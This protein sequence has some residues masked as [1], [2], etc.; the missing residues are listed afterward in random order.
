MQKVRFYFSGTQWWGGKKRK[1]SS[2]D[3]A[4]KESIPAI[5]KEEGIMGGKGTREGGLFKKFVIMEKSRKSVLVR[6]RE[7]FPRVMRSKRGPEG[8]PAGTSERKCCKGS[9]HLGEITL[10]QNRTLWCTGRK[11]RSKGSDRQAS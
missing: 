1:K 3:H 11:G 8:E 6:E 10:E 7:T 5:L 2:A 4:L 9:H